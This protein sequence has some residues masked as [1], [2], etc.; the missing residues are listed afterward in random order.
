MYNLRENEHQE[1]FYP[2]IDPRQPL[3]IH[4]PSP[5]GRLG[6]YVYL[7]VPVDQVA[8]LATVGVHAEVG[9]LRPE[10]LTVAAGEG[11][12]EPVVLASS[13]PG[14]AWRCLC[15]IDVSRGDGTLSLLDWP[16]AI[17][18]AD[19]LLCTWPRFVASGQADAWLAAQA[20][21]QWA[22]TGVPLGGIGGGRVDLC[23]DGRFRNFSMNNNQDA[24]LEDPDGLP[25][26]YLAVTVD[27]ST[28]DLASRPIVDGH[29]AC[30]TLEYTPCFPQVTLSAPELAPGLT[31]EVTASGMLCPHDLRRSSLPAFLVRWEICNT[32]TEERTVQCRFGWPNLI[33]TGG[34]IGRAETSIGYGDGYYHHWDDPSGRR[35]TLREVGGALAVQFTGDPAPM[36]LASRG[37]HLL[38]VLAEPG[39]SVDAQPGDGHGEVSAILTVPAGSCAQAWMALVTAMPYWVDS[40]GTDRGI[41]WQNHFADGQ[42]MLATVF[43]ERD[44]IFAETG[45]LAA[46]LADSTLP[47]WLAMRLSNCTYPLVTNSVFYRDGRFSINEGPTEMAGC[48]GTIDQR[49]A[50]HP[51]TQLL[52]PM[53]N[54]TELELFARIQ[55]DNGGIVHDLGHGHL[56]RGPGDQPWPDIPCSFV[57]QTARHAWSTGDTA[58]A[59]AM[60]P[61]AKHALQRHGA[62]ADAGDGVAQVGHRLGTSYDS[63]HYFGTTAYVGTL[64]LAALAVAERWAGLMG[65]T[66]LLPEI[67]RW[68]T[69]AIARLDADLWNGRYYDAYGSPQ[70]AHRE[71]CHAGQ[72]AGQVYTRLLCGDDVLPA[73]RLQPVAAALVAMNGSPRFQ[74]PPDEVAADGGVGSDF[75]WLPY[76]EGFMLSAL[77]SVDPQALW[78]LWARVVAAMH[79]DGRRP[80][81]TR[82]M[83]RPL[84][85]EASWGSYYMTAPASW[86]VYDGLLDFWYSP[87]DGTLRLHVEKPGR[88]PLVHPLFWATAEV[89]A[90]GGVALTITRVF[91]ETP[92]SLRALEVPVTVTGVRMHGEQLCADMTSNRFNRYCLREPLVFNPATTIEWALT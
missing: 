19:M 61:R 26:A 29:Q 38:G 18:Q 58:F 39:C 37:A 30:R 83:Y 91:T 45:A 8:G 6:Y 79:D 55:G 72:L 62:W 12:S 43:A 88:Y 9:G 42:E 90:A 57:I 24:P 71:T 4:I 48:Y 22:P 10:D 51:A 89:D 64:W 40:Q 28:I 82:L 92:L 11:A 16:A 74:V 66:A 60:W 69:A 56:E 49:L 50:A 87:E 46:H 31:A 67:A 68:R 23:R 2:A 77:A 47:D 54:A 76:V 70:G 36:A 80:C 84:T 81:D 44:A 3:V 53:L 73:E 21:A 5:L 7:R 15:C 75:G 25:G 78:P 27:G 63:Y 34:G 1:L 14:L 52:F 59:A 17:T 35:E 20:D 32:G 13:A 86:L 33:G 85:G 65:D 41:Y